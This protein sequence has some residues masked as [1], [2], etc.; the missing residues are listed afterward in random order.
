MRMLICTFVVR[1]FSH[2]VALI[3][4]Q[5]FSEIKVPIGAAYSIAFGLRFLS[6]TDYVEKSPV[7]VASAEI[8]EICCRQ[9]RLSV[10]VIPRYLAN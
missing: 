7:L 3:I 2:N 8:S 1:R 10:I 4:W 6:L 9:S 5:P